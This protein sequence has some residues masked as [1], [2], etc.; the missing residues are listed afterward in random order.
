MKADKNKTQQLLLYKQFYSKQYGT[1]IENIDVEYFIVKRKLWENTDFPQKRV[2]KFVPASGKPS[3]NKVNNRL[4]IFLNEAFT[5]DG[6]R[7]NDM[8]ATPSKKACK[9][10]EFKGTE[11]CK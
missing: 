9:W 8:V 7:K 11:Y 10:C 1:P 3:M 5:E 6:E 4:N 2:Q